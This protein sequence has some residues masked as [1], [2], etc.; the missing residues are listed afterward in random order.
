[1]S[2]H[3][4]ERERVV[5]HES[6]SAA[7]ACSKGDQ[8]GKPSELPPASVVTPKGASGAVVPGVAEKAARHEATSAAC[9][10]A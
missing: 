5:A 4:G 1:M 10:H 2:A 9:W 8:R 6:Q 7:A 3:A